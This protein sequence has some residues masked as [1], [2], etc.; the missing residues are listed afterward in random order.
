[1]NTELVDVEAMRE[2]ADGCGLSS[3]APKSQVC[4]ES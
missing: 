1:M 4:M 3:W 2:M